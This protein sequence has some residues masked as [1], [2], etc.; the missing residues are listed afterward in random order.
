MV[1]T[2]NGFLLAE[3]DLEQ[4]GPGDFIGY[5][6]SGY[7]D[8]QMASLSDIRLIEKA[9]RFA[10]EVL[11]DDPLLEKTEN[12]L[13]KGKLSTLWKTIPSDIS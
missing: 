13:I 1:D 2:T 6:Q 5:R 12:F 11:I 7:V 9:R 4:R 10:Q 3:K 8:L